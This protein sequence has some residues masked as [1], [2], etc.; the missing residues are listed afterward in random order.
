MQILPCSRA[1]FQDEL[2]Q[3]RSRRLGAVRLGLTFNAAAHPAL[4]PVQDGKYFR[5]RDGGKRRNNYT[6]NYTEAT[7][8]RLL[9]LHKLLPLARAHSHTYK[10]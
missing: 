8:S 2:Y 6:V 10:G 9:G 5:P 3:A 7:P 1:L 4:C